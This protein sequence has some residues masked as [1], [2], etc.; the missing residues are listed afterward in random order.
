V[1]EITAVVVT[2]VVSSLLPSLNEGRFRGMLLN[3]HPPGW[4]QRSKAETR[5][6]YNVGQGN[7]SD[8]HLP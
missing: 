1:F 7:R 2:A 6:Y 3:D 5:P 8:E 4:T